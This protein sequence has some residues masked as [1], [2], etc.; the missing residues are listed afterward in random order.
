MLK[1]I[2]KICFVAI[3]SIVYINNLNA[4]NNNF[5]LDKTIADIHNDISELKYIA[6]N[7]KIAIATKQNSN[8]GLL[9]LMTNYYDFYELFFN[10]DFT[11][12]QSKKASQANRL[13]VL[14]NFDN[15][16]VYY[17]HCKAMI[18]LQW[19][20]IKLKHKEYFSAAKDLR[21]AY[22]QF[23]ENKKKFPQTHL[24]DTYIGAINCAVGAIPKSFQTIATTLG[25]G[26]DR[27]N[28]LLWLKEGL[29]TNPFKI[30]AI[31]FYTY[32][33]QYIE[34]NTDAAWKYISSYKTE[35]L[36]NRLLTFMIA[37]IA[38]NQNKAEQ[39][40]SALLAHINKK[41]FLQLPILNYE[42]ACTYLY[43]L[44]G[45]CI[46]Y[47]KDYISNFK[48]NYYKKDACHKAALMCYVQNNVN[49]ANELIKQINNYKITDA[50]ADKQ[51]QAFYKNPVWPNKDL[52]QVRLLFDG[53][54]YNKALALCNA[55]NVQ[56]NNKLEYTYRKARLFEALTKQDSAIAY[57]KN[58]IE[59]GKEETT[60]F[61]ARSCIQLGG[62]LE[63]RNNKK[64]AI[65]YYKL[66]MDLPNEEYVA[67]IEI[68][69]KAGLNRLK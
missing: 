3:I 21:N 55:L 33:M 46:T 65:K 66:A 39:A 64:E 61:A 56:T 13:K 38:L 9:I 36:D 26:N 6:A 29:K 40:Q 11:Q 48:G 22:L 63:K 45:K 8:N 15:T 25:L 69:A 23:I 67:G 24:G 31:F 59:L 58:T 32:I 4:S 37:N 7:T 44:D 68:K 27:K 51:A 10:E 60:Y 50:D 42:I 53:G 16:S 57:Y 62:I 17:L 41:G 12:Y 52:L 35:A 14:D 34:N 54:Y 18:N 30:D 2:L 5:V 49:S 1:T 19:G 43:Q 20:F 47:F 28:G